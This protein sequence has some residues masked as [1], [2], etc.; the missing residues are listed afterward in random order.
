[1]I[2]CVLVNSHL[3]QYHLANVP[4]SS[5]VFSL[6]WQQ[7]GPRACARWGHRPPARVNVFISISVL[8]TKYAQYNLVFLGW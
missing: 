4:H 5:L 2:K 1:M 7:A 8:C 6:W 3:Q